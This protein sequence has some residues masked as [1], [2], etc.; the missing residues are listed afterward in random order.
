[1]GFARMIEQGSE[2]LDDLVRSLAGR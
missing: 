2:K 1:M